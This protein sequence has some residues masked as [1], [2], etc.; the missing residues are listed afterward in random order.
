MNNATVNLGGTSSAVGAVSITGSQLNLVGTYT[1]AQLKGTYSTTQ[2]TLATGGT[3]DNRNDTLALDATTGSWT[4]A[5]G[6]LLGGT[7]S[8]GGGAALLFTVQR[9][10]LDGVTA[11]S[12]LDLASNNNAQATIV[13]GLTLLGSTIRLGNAAGT[14]SGS[15][16][17]Q[18][19]QTLLGTGSVLLGAYSGNNLSVSGGTL[20]LDT[21]ITVQG[22]AGGLL[23]NTILNKGKILADGSGG[24]VGTL[25]VNASTFTNQGSLAA[26]NGET[27]IVSGT[28]TPNA[29][30]ITVGV[31]SVVSVSSNYTQ[32]SGGTLAVD[33]GGTASGQYGVLKVI[34]GS[35][36]LAGTLNV[37]LVNG[38]SPKAG[39]SI[40]IMTFPSATGQFDTVNVSGLPAGI[41][42]TVVY[43]AKNVSLVFG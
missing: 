9:G 40:P 22:S 41:G 37:S 33:V 23:G 28:L 42:M 13:D 24:K 15:L 12:D 1:T 4:L 39:D 19:T 26:S 32:A 14:T 6:T 20:T 29:G 25:Q 5:G 27:L 34:F 11:A 10:T 38:Y 18:G 31:G 16:T 35:A 21:N 8:A 3:L 43:G 30:T 17:F 2:V 7:Y 36:T